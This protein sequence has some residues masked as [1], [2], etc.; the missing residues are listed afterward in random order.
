M[1]NLISVEWNVTMYIKYDLSRNA[2]KRKSLI[3]FITQ[4][5]EPDIVCKLT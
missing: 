5:V 2:V 1:N 3:Y 4:N